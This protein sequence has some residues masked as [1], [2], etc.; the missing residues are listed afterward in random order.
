MIFQPKNMDST[1]SPLWQSVTKPHYKE[2][3]M[4]A[5]N[6]NSMAHYYKLNQSWEAKEI[7]RLTDLINLIL[8]FP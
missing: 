1:I 4:F 2:W 6:I 3:N 5:K 7:T 8:V